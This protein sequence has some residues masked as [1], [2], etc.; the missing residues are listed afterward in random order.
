VPPSLDPH[1]VRHSSRH[2]P[3]PTTITPPKTPTDLES[4]SFKV[5]LC[6]SQFSNPNLLDL[7][8]FLVKFS[9]NILILEMLVLN[10]LDC[11]WILD[12]LGLFWWWSDGDWR[13]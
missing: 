13:D 11:S 6:L 8:I 10:V 4:P 3:S 12:L 5:R 2:Y 1:H 9:N 7:S